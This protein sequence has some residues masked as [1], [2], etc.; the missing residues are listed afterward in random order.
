MTKPIDDTS[1]TETPVTP[2]EASARAVRPTAEDA[3]LQRV[4]KYINESLAGYSGGPI[5]VDLSRLAGAT[6]DVLMAAAAQFTDRG[7]H[8]TIL[9][10]LSTLRFADAVPSETAPE[11]REASEAEAR[12]RRIEDAIEELRGRVAVLETAGQVERYVGRW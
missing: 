12:L 8:V 4:V 2:A 6:P 5:D 10:G 1:P 9:V 7:W 3:P 11:E